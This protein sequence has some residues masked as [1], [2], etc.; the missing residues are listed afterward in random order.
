MTLVSDQGK[1]MPMD[2]IFESRS[3]G[4]KIRYTT[5]A[6]GVIDWKGDQISY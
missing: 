3:Y 4:F 1:P 5:A 2:W 6:E